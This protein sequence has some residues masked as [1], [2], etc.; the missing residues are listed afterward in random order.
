MSRKLGRQIKQK[1]SKSHRND[2]VQRL[3]DDCELLAKEHKLTCCLTIPDAA[4]DL[5][6]TADL[7]KRTIT[8]AM[9]LGA[10]QDKVR[11]SARVN[12]LIKQVSKANADGFYVKAI[13]PGRA[14]ETQTPLATLLADGNAL[15]TL[16]TNVVPSAFEV[17]YMADLGKRSIN[18]IL[19]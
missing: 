14:E 19:R 3:K 9:R 18:P 7:T 12:W 8:C 5:D 17:F 13:R 6:I 10:P 4:A 11:S 15:E 2:P 16:S 1:I